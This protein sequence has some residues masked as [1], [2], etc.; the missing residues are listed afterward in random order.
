MTDEQL[1][2]FCPVGIQN[3]WNAYSMLSAMETMITMVTISMVTSVIQKLLI[4]KLKRNAE[5]DTFTTI[6]EG[7]Q[8]LA[9]LLFLT[10][11]RLGQKSIIVDLCATVVDI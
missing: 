6:A 10:K 8:A 4:I 11:S 1:S 9:G 3:I 7:A 5:I 2:L